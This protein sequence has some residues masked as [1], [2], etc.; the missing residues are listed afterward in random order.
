MLKTYLRLL[1]F[2]KPIGRY[3]VPYFF[4]SLLYALFNSCT[5]LLIIPILNTMFK[6][7]YAFEVVEKLPPVELDSAYLET[8]FN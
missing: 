3:A 4:Y 8:L 6:P 7:D 2:A 1:G 5:F